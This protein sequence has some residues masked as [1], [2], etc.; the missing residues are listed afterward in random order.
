MFPLTS[1]FVFAEGLDVFRKKV[2]ATGGRRFPSRNLSFGKDN[3]GWTD[4]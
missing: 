1:F 4:V 2:S 3:F